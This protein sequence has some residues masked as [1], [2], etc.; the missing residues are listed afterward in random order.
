MITKKVKLGFSFILLMTVVF[1]I[2]YFIDVNKKLNQGISIFSKKQHVHDKA[3]LISEP[4]NV[5]R[6]LKNFHKDHNIQFVVYTVKDIHADD[7]VKYAV[8]LFEKLRIGEG[9][10]GNGILLLIS[11]KEQYAQ[12]TVSMSIEHV[13]TD[14]LSGSVQEKQFK[15]YF[16]FGD[17]T[18]AVLDVVDMLSNWA[19]DYSADIEGAK[20]VSDESQ[21]LTLGAGAK[22]THIILGQGIKAKRY[23]SPKEKLQFTAQGSPLETFELY[24]QTLKQNISDP[25]LDIYT[26]GSQFMLGY[27]PWAEYQN[28]EFLQTIE[29]GRPFGVQIQGDY[30]VIQMVAGAK[31]K[32]PY[33]L[34]RS[35]D[36][37]KMD[38]MSYFRD[39][40]NSYQGD[41]FLHNWY[42][43]YNFAF[44][45]TKNHKMVIRNR[46][47][48]QSKI[49]SFQNK[50]TKDK[51]TCENY[52]FLADVY[53]DDCWMTFQAL[54]YYEKA[55][56]LCQDNPQISRKIADAYYRIYYPKHSLK[57]Y[58]KLA[59]LQPKEKRI[60]DRLHY[61][62]DYSENPI[63]SLYCQF[64][65]LLLGK[66]S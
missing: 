31:R 42:S 18:M 15:P 48:V 50:I 40:R 41:W 54:E 38:L 57:Y 8:D 39:M 33:F 43:P 13:F 24:I 49:D 27:W 65:S 23:L 22:V 2:L 60:W 52:A 64:R 44:K 47:N 12:L 66:R 25:S 10:K 34:Y 62:Y 3:N 59:E 11:Q 1:L 63:M 32:M 19:F 21:Y 45:K 51:T 4:F 58:W 55:Y 36:G 14:L 6:R 35:N 56:D 61:F 46:E 16:E 53:W 5:Y 37:W 7:L 17:V 29:Q 9:S 20:G 30:A 26:E 28:N